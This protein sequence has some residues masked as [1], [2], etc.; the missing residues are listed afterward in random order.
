VIPAHH[1]CYS[2]IKISEA[3]RT[4][5]LCFERSISAASGYDLFHFCLIAFTFSMAGLLAFE[6]I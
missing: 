2:V 1:I 4:P 6:M 3:V 5:P